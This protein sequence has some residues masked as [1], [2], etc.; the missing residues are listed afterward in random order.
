[1]ASMSDHLHQFIVKG[2]LHLYFHSSFASFLVF[3]LNAIVSVT[4]ENF[5]NSAFFGSQNALLNVS[6]N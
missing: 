4:A 3:I 5:E 2:F 6:S 1:V